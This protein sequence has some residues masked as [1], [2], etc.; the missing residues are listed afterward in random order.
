MR[1][2]LWPGCSPQEHFSEMSAYLAG[3]PAEAAFVAVRPQGGLGGFLEASLRRYADGCDT[4]PVGYV[5]GWHVDP[6]LRR[7][8][9]GAQLVAAAENWARALGCREMASD[10][11]LDNEVSLQAHLALGYE[12][13]DRLIHFRKALD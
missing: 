5:E 13:T 11:L 1:R 7:Q 4:S 9:I 8:G 2:A 6:D 12:E 10:C 3:D